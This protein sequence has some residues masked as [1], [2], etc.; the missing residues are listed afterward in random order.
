MENINF[1]QDILIDE[2]ALEMEWLNQ[3]SLA[4]KYSKYWA[5]C[6]DK[7]NKLQELIKLTRA[8]LVHEVV[9]DPKKYLGIDKNPTGPMIE[10]YYRNHARHI[11]I[12]K[13]IVEA[14]YELDIAEAAKK[15]ISISRKTALEYLVK[16][17]GLNYFSG[18]S[19][20][21]DINESKLTYNKNKVVS[22]EKDKNIGK[23]LKR[24]KK[25]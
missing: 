2:N 20:P 6:A 8:E 5:K 24:R 4:Y 7:L 17:L 18:P 14:Q 9:S 19:V 22:Q 1:E 11:K 12:K 13:D 15:E 21:R 25:E 23:R 16:L 3:P 10:A